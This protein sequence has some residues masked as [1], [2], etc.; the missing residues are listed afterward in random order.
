MKKQRI[1]VLIFITVI[2]VGISCNNN[3]AKEDKQDA[4]K[5]AT[6]SATAIDGSWDLV[7]GK[8]NDTIQPIKKSVQFKQFSNGFFSMIAWGDSGKLSYCGYGKYELNGRSY[9]ETFL[10]HNNPEYVGGMDWQEYELKGD[11]L[12]TKGFIK[13]IIG[14]KEETAKFPKIE[15]KRVRAK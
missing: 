3:P 11:T 13:V 6:A 5:T 1:T 4:A 12:Y 7:W 14:G 10:Y 2:I 9:K 15:E 8:Y